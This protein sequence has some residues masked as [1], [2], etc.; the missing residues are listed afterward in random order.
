M[1]NVAIVP[2]G[3]QRDS[4]THIHVSILPQTPLPFRLPKKHWTGF[5]VLC[6][7]F[8]WVIRLKRSSV[9]MSTP[10]CLSPSPLEEQTLVSSLRGTPSRP[11][12]T[13]FVLEGNKFYKLGPA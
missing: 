4:A 1:I 10:N 3:Q 12:D 11:K 6:S 7:R 13:Q 2:G 9:Y 8:L 5:P